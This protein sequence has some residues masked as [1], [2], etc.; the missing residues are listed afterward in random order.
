MSTQLPSSGS[1]HRRMFY[2]DELAV[3]QVPADAPGRGLAPGVRPDDAAAQGGPRLDLLRDLT[4]LGDDACEALGAPPGAHLAGPALENWAQALIQWAEAGVAG[5]RCRRPL[6]ID[7]PAWRRLITR[8]HEKCPEFV[9]V[10]WTPGL[11]PAQLATLEHAGFSATCLSLPWWD[12]RAPWL[13]EEYAR[14]SRVAPVIAP[15]EDMDPTQS[16]AGKPGLSSM[17]PLTNRLWMAA[18][19]CDSLLLTPSAASEVGPDMLDRVGRWMQQPPAEQPLRAVL[20][21]AIPA[22]RPRIACLTGP[23]AQLAGFARTD[24]AASVLIINPETETSTAVDWNMLAARLPDDYV[25][26]DDAQTALPSELPP[27]GLAVVELFHA[28]RAG[29]PPL[30]HATHRIA[31]ENVTPSID[32]GDFSAKVCLGDPVRVRVGIF[33]DGHER[34]SACLLWRPAT[35]ASWQRIT[36][37]ETGNDEWEASFYPMD[38]GVCFYQ[39]QAWRDAWA[40][41]R[42]YLGKKA[43]AGLDV[44]LEIEEGRILLA[45][46]AAR[47]RASDGELAERIEGFREAVQ[48][49]AAQAVDILLSMSLAHAMQAA[50]DHPF[51]ACSMQYSLTVDRRRARYASWYE[52]FPR[53]QGAQP[54]QH[55]TLLDVAA[56]VPDIAAMGFDVLYFP[57]IHPI[58][59]TNRKGRNNALRAET[60]DPGSPYAIGASEGGHDALHPELGSLEDFQALVAVAR[61]HGME[62]AMDFAIQCS[63]DHPWL[64]QHP[65]WFDWRADGSLRFAENPPKRYEDIVNPDFYDAQGRPRT[66]LWEALRDV[67]LFWTEQGVSTF[68]VD[69]PHTKPVPFWHWMIA[70][71]KARHPQVIFLS[72]AFTRPKMMYRLAKAGFSQSYTYF[73]WRN[74]K[75][76]LQDYLHQLTVSPISDFFRPNFFVNTPDIN[77]WFLQQGGRPAFLIRAALATTLSGLWGMYQGFELCEALGLPGKE[78]Y[79]NAEKYEIRQ[80][81]MDRPGHIVAEISRL[82][83]LRRENPALQ[84]HLGVRFHEVDNER[85]LFFTKTTREADNVVVAAIS[86]DPH[87]GQ[88]GTL[89]LPFWLW[90]IPDGGTA[91]FQDLWTDQR[92]QVTGR[93]HSVALT[94][95]QPFVLWRL[96][97]S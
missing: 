79:Q 28:H 57:P 27:S 47:V 56:R 55:G 68:R 50:D 45:R 64:Q 87:A 7:A 17:M 96:L 84:S 85:I 1:L 51:E 97:P 26:Q 95:A 49:Q 18:F 62:I 42:E 6:E 29:S 44:A 25:F 73:T 75:P 58:G 10:A 63:P 92:F 60:G 74:T 52:L 71:I 90:D 72:E 83:R 34:I 76:E 41:F 43:Q 11:T 36:M 69:N 78:E 46:A 35:Q 82:N 8:V 21:P 31:I 37:Q 9:F 16:A 13:L 5:V 3:A 22:P 14:L 2:V 67:V 15:V 12:G 53:S 4:L 19:F 39:V 66:D 70:D 93:Y 33:S 91:H 20:A 61:S 30:Q 48:A 65:D 86:L 81:D 40:S 38:V 24:A 89:Q 59:L 94:P 80:W 54:G 32:G 77:P 88:G 23:L